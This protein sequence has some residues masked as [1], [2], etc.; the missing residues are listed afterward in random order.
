MSILKS[1]LGFR[2]V[3]MPTISYRYSRRRC[4]AK[5]VNMSVVRISK[6]CYPMNMASHIGDCLTGYSCKTVIMRVITTFGY[7]GASQD[8]VY[9][10]HVES[11]CFIHFCLLLSFSVI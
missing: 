4:P 3:N 10:L 5:F 6:K 7:E 11:I 9:M 2:K 8:F 1:R